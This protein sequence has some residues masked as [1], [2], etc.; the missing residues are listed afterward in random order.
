MRTTPLCQW[1]A[2]AVEFDAMLRKAAEDIFGFPMSDF[3]YAQAALTPKLGGLGLRKATE[4]AG[5]AFSASWH[6][7]KKQSIED[8]KQRQEWAS[9][10]PRRARLSPSTRRFC[11]T[12]WTA[13]TA[14]TPSICVAPL[15]PTPEASSQPYLLR[16]M[17]TT[18]SFAPAISVSRLPTAWVS[19]C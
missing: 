3:T 6:E 18:P 8:W 12:W 13:R 10:C 2:Q 11:S 5:L 17:G 16:R 4:H 15:S 1:R 19:R 9:T 14:G 7:A